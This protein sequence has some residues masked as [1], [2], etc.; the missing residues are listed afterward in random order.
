[1]D[2]VPRELQWAEAFVALADTLLDDFDMHVLAEHCVTLLNVTAAGVM[3]ADH[4]GRLR[5]T[6]SSTERAELLELFDLQNDEGPGLDCYTQGTAVSEGGLGEP[7]VHSRWPRFAAKARAAGFRSVVALP[8]R[9][10]DE[11]IGALNMFSERPRPLQPADHLLGQALA[12]VATIG[13][14]Q[15][16]SVQRREELAQQLQTALNSRVVIEQATGVLAERNRMDVE[17]AFQLLRNTARARRVR[18]SDFACLVLGEAIDRS[19]HQRVVV[20]QV[21]NRWYFLHVTLSR[22][23]PWR[24]FLWG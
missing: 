4:E 17:S 19:P 2:E 24:Q 11:T 15:Q 6:A 14:L 22:P 21:P 3:I 20:P 16:R 8:L 18:L 10:R 12:D 23:R 9:W 13:L 5:V 1:M 7:D